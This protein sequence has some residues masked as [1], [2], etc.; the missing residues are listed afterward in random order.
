MTTI[1]IFVTQQDSEQSDAH[2]VDKADY[3]EALE[4]AI[5]WLEHEREGAVYA[6]DVEVGATGEYPR[7]RLEPDDEGELQLGIA[8]DPE[9]G[10]VRVAFGKGVKWLA[11][12]ADDVGR[13]CALLMHKAQEVT[14]YRE[15]EILKTHG[16][17]T[18]S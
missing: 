6:P 18:G 16:S 11:F 8:A 1:S 15:L 14:A 4:A 9:N 7:G 10:V 17:D 5:D 13:F 3:V 2:H 12:S